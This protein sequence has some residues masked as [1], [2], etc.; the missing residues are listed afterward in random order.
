MIE[1]VQRYRVFLKLRVKVN[2]S[3]FNSENQNKIISDTINVKIIWA[4]NKY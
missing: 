1:T 3:N 4:V 2:F